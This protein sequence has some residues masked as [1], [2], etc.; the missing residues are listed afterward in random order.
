MK[1][2]FA[3]LGVL[4]FVGSL[5]QAQVYQLNNGFV[6][7]E[8]V[9]TCSGYFYDSN[10]PV[11]N[12]NPGENYT[13]TFCPG[14]VGTY[15]D[16]DFTSFNIGTSDH[17]EVYDGPNTSS[18]SFGTFTNLINPV[19]MIIRASAGNTSGCL[20]IFFQSSSAAPGWAATISC[21]IP[22]QQLFSHIDSLQTIPNPNDTNYIEV[23]P[24]SP[25]TFVAFGEYPQNDIVYHQCD[26]SCLFIWTF[27][28][29]TSDTGKVVT[30]LFDTIRGYDVTVIA[31][32]QNGCISSNL[33]ATRVMISQNPLTNILPLEPMCAFDTLPIT[34]GYDP[35]STISISPVGHVQSGGLDLADTTFL[36]D[37]SGA[38]YTTSLTFSVFGNGQTLTSASDL[39][40]ICAN[41]EHS[42]LGDLEIVI[43]CPSG[44]SITLKQYPG[45]S[46]TFLG[47]PIDN[48]AN[49]NMG[50][51][52]DYCWHSNPTYGTMVSEANMHFYTFTD[53]AGTT[54][55]NHAY[56]P[57]GSYQSFEAL[58][59]LVGCPLNGTWTITVT[60]HLSIDNGYIFNW[61][62]EF[63]SA[64]IPGNWSYSVPLES[65][66]WQ[67]PYISTINDTTFQFVADTGGTYD[68]TVII[69]DVFGCQYDTILSIDIVD[70]PVV[71]LGDDIV[72]CRADAP[73]ITIYGETEFATDYLWSTS[74]TSNSLLVDYDGFYSLTAT[75]NQGNVACSS[76]DTVE[77]KF[78]RTPVFA[79]I[80]DTCIEHP[81][82]LSVID[83][84]LDSTYRFS[85]S[86][87][88]TTQSITVSQTGNYWVDVWIDAEIVCSHGDGVYVQ[89]IPPPSVDLGP[90][91]IICEFDTLT[92]FAGSG[93]QSNEYTYSWSP[94]IYI[95]VF[96]FFD[97]PAPGEYFVS[98][99]KRGCTDVS[100]E[101]KVTVND[102]E[103]F[104][105]NVFTPDGDGIN[106]SFGI[107]G[108][109]NYD[110]VS[111]LVYNR[112]GRKVYESNDYRNDW[113]GEKL[114]DGTYFYIIT[115]PEN[116]KGPFTGSLTILRK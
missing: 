35:N 56:L 37:G 16:L 60:D 32:D 65:V 74:L 94:A 57:P 105:P 111:L 113:Y 97:P 106:E 14:T 69:T 42:Y 39:L 71:D 92:F 70:V 23:C 11:G 1:L 91:R 78:I 108:I 81:I 12:Y 95:G 46:S 112:W 104:I 4:I 84:L 20:T 48:D 36:P 17:F 116:Q 110:H 82:A 45:G 30:H 115:F 31:I 38:S 85:W 99:I 27:G 72:V 43:S 15:V 96:A 103:V 64:L 49:L 67:S 2:K 87:N 51:G 86:T 34:V 58:G 98:V 22:C 102:C 50:V 28:D 107:D 77:V 21:Q 55:T 101:V 40:G 93:N 100:D 83:P 9:S 13:V 62:I 26:D 61:G 47:E 44:T 6:N 63:S 109:E 33:P 114:S 24:D 75:N 52:Y 18:P 88:Q 79:L 54:Y 73:Y 8:T 25:V 89:Y 5:L 68:V 53:N 7:G 29:G 19:N 80:S 66:E 59:G 10:G 41:M 3:F 76:S 90:D